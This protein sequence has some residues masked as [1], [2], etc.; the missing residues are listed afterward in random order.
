[1]ALLRKNKK[2]LGKNL[3]HKRIKLGMTLK[4]ISKKIAR[5]VTAISKWETS[6]Y[7]PGPKS[8]FLLSKA[9]KVEAEYFYEPQN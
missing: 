9:L 1:M 7:Q 2:F 6:K 3:Y 5:S 8:I 4:D